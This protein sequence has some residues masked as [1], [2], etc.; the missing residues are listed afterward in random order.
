MYILAIDSLLTIHRNKREQVKS[1]YYFGHRTDCWYR[2]CHHDDHSSVSQVGPFVYS[3]PVH[4]TSVFKFH[5]YVPFDVRVHSV[6]CTCTVILK[7]K[8]FPS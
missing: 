2:S 8:F 3:E 4:W 6:F 7:C 1:Y 5:T